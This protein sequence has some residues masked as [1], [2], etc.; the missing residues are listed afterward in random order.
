MTE[1]RVA[2]AHNAAPVVVQERLL[3]DPGVDVLIATVD[4]LLE[5][6][7]RKAIVFDDV[8]ILVLDEA[9]RMVDMGQA[10]ESRK[11]PKRLPEPRTK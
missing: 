4:R 11:R 10:T 7:A 8:E 3:R 5:L 9:D 2:L 6:H 1:L